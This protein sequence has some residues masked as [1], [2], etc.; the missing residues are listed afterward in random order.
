MDRDLNRLVEEY[1]RIFRCRRFREEDLDD[2]R[3]EAYLPFLKRL[4][5]VDGSSVAVYD[6]HR[7]RYAFLTESFKFLLGYDRDEALE[8]GP[9]YFYPRMHPEDLPFVLD[10]VVRCLRFLLNLPPSERTAYRLGFDFRIRRADG[11]YIRLLQQVVVLDSDKRGNIRLVLI[12]N[13]LLRDVPAEA[14]PSRR[15][16][17]LSDGKTYLFAPD[18]SSCA[19]DRGNLLTPR[20]IEVLGLVAVGLA[21]D[22]IG[23]RLCISTATVNNHRG[24]ILEKLGV[25]NSAEAV[26][27]AAERGLLRG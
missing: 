17:N 14:S 2:T 19:G 11:C 6:L 13:D 1:D 3:I 24:H 4:D 27:W 26:A 10:T 22:E 18:S 9:D 20:E 21:S 7:Q 15:L 25:R 12:V 23:D 16:L 8:A 5:A